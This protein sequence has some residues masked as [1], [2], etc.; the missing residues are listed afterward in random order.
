MLIP[1]GEHVGRTHAGFL[2]CEVTG[3]PRR[4]QG[5]DATSNG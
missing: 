3:N 1:K 2:P 5:A 4:P